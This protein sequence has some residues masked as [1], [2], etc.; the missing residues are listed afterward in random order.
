L[1]GNRQRFIEGQAS[2]GDAS[3]AARELVGQRRPLDQLHDNRRR[4]SGV[5][6]AV[7]RGARGSRQAEIEHFDL[8]RLP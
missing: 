6:E 1:S 5:F 8:A 3:C 7:N 4:A 2:V